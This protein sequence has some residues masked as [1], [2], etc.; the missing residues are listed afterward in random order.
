MRVQT[1]DAERE[2]QDA[3]EQRAE[4]PWVATGEG[5][6]EGRGERDG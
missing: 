2:L 4:G 6:L 3:P 5:L 1:G